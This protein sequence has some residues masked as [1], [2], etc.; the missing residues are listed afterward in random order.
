[1]S[2][3]ESSSEGILQK[4]TPNFLRRSFALKFG[5]VLLVMG[6][7]VGII[8]FA[9]T[10]EVRT[11]TQDNVEGQFQNTA[12]QQS[13][14][15]EQWVTQNKLSTKLISNQDQ[16][17]DDEADLE[18]ALQNELS[19]LSADA[20]NVHLLETT[21]SGSS[22]V[23]STSLRA[24]SSAL[25]GN[26][27]WTSET[28][29]SD[30]SRVLVSDAYRDSQDS[31]STIGFASPVPASQNRI[32]VV[33]Y[34]LDELADSI[35]PAEDESAR[36]TQVVD[37]HRTVVV[38]QA[39][40]S[41]SDREGMTLST[42]PVQQTVDDANALRGTQE[43][44][45][46]K[47]TMAPN[48]DLGLNEEYTVGYAPV[49]GTD[50]VVLTHAPSST[51]FG[52]V[53]DVQLYGLIATA[54][55]VVF[56]GGIGAALGWSTSSS[57]DTLTRKTEEMR[58][59]NLDVELDTS[60]IDNIGRLY[61]GFADM[62][63]ALREQIDEAERARKEAEVS[64]AEAMEMSN[65]L[66]EKATEF[67]VAMEKTAGGDMTTRMEQDGENEAMDTIA[68]E[69][70]AM[71][72]ELEKTTGQLKSFSEEVAES[73]DVVLQSAESVRDA[74]EQVAESIQKISDDAYEQKDQLQ[75]ISEDLDELVET[76]EALE[77]EQQAVDLGDSL[78]QFRTV[79][80]QLQ[81]AADTSEQMMSESETVAGAA[82]EQAAELN[83]VSSRAEQ[84]K[85]Y[86]RP[87][88]DILDRFE[89]EAEHEFVFSGG[90]SQTTRTQE[91]SEE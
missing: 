50:W 77:A 39:Y 65:Y 17:G 75:T 37:S 83:E 32:L 18:L 28:E 42:Y 5:L 38:D 26:L 15:V 78:T 84:L 12:V 81:E 46:V 3:T 89:T 70:N 69:F 51:V 24:D 67:S 57:I 13:D 53:E 7:S 71:I 55:L 56:I 68:S 23:A 80:T 36:F 30:T 14:I 34:R 1:M 22:V 10:E 19:R 27:Q 72:E 59:G 11:Q 41:N 40:A 8:G 9:A 61:D 29:L 91:E 25:S 60:R 64:R 76:L 58:E 4:I 79:A 63:D 88:G 74:S 16:W 20:K 82:E 31:E 86:A 21:P 54:G 49:S 33:E 52:F 35:S 73:G 43:S 62:R 45:S 85:R 48:A 2:D 44:A 66:Q 90:P 87:L 6:L 47:T